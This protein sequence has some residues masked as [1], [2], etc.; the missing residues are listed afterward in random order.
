[1]A[2]CLMLCVLSAS[3]GALW[4]HRPPLAVLMAALDRCVGSLV[5]TFAVAALID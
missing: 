3:D 4:E 1:M 5:C 2:A